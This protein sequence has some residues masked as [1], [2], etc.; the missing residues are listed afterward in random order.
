MPMMALHARGNHPPGRDCY[1]I[2]HQRH[3]NGHADHIG[4]VWLD[5]WKQR[6]GLWAYP[7]AYNGTYTITVTGATIHLH[8]GIK[9][10]WIGHHH[11]AFDRPWL[12]WWT[13]REPGMT[14]GRAAQLGGVLV[15]SN[16]VDVPQ[17]WAGSKNCAPCMAGRAPGRQNPLRRSK[18]TFWPSM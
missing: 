6:N 12:L 14:A 3:D 11:R 13:S 4:G 8:H 15:M 2:H 5:H 16:G 7:Y 9:P 18:T 10:W 1:C 17:Y